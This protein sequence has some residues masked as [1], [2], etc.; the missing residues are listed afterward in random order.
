MSRCKNTNFFSEIETFFNKSGATAIQAMI[1]A[2]KA[3]KLTDRMPTLETR[4]NATMKTSE[5]LIVL[6]LLSTPVGPLAGFPLSLISFFQQSK[7]Q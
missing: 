3:I 4:H 2:L 7:C 6:L 1:T 5:K